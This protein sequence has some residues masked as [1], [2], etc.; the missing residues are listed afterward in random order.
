MDSTVR[1][2]ARPSVRKD[3][4]PFSFRAVT[5][6]MTEPFA[7]SGAK[8]SQAGNLSSPAMGTGVPFLFLMEG[9]HVCSKPNQCVSTA[10]RSARRPV[11]STTFDRA[12]DS[13]L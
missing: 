11:R 6:A 1:H 2:A 13:Q 9:H 12:D 7:P 5:R 3:R 8:L 10:R 4:G